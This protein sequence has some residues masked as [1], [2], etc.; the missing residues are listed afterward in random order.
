MCCERCARNKEVKM[1]VYF[2]PMC[3]EYVVA[4][5][6]FDFRSQGF[7]YVKHSYQVQGVRVSCAVCSTVVVAH[8]HFIF[9]LLLSFSLLIE[10]LKCLNSQS[11]KIEANSSYGTWH[12]L[13]NELLW[14]ALLE[15]L[16]LSFICV[17]R[18]TVS[19]CS[20]SSA[21]TTDYLYSKI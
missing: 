6:I 4:L 20:N 14:E 5:N 19:N 18:G 13:H 15:Y 11:L 21:E 2:C 1:P 16:F 9:I 3:S 10:D 7:W 12:L 17:K 8:P